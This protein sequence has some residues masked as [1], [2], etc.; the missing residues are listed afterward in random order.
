MFVVVKDLVGLPG[1]PATTKGIR[2]A[3]ERASGDSPA[4]VRKREGSKAFEY[5]IDCL[6]AAVREV[7]LARRAEAVLQK[8]EVQGQLPLEPVVPAARGRAEALRVSVE[9][10][11]MRKCPALLE[12]QLGSLTDKQRKTGDARMTLVA[13]V[14]RL[15]GELSMSRK[16]AVTL[17]SVRSREG[18]LPERVQQAADIANARKGVTRTGVSVRSLQQWV[19]DAMTT[20]TAGE[21]M[22]IMAP[23]KIKAKPAEAYPWLSDFMRFYRDPAR[24]S[25]A[26]AYERFEA[27]WCLVNAGND[28]MLS[29]LPRVDTVR[30]ALSKIP[31]AERE[32]GRRTGSDYKSLLPHVRRDW[33]KLSANSVWIGDGHGMKMEVISPTTGKPFRPEITLVIDGRTRVVVG[34]SLA[35]SESQMAVGDAIRHAVSRFGVPL[36]YYSDNG[37]GEKNK[38]FDADVT[39]IFSRLEIEH[40][41][42]IPGNPQARGIIERLNQEIPKRAAMA[43]GSWVGKSGDRETQRKYVKAVESAVNAIENG[44]NLNER[45]LAVMH[46]VPTWEQLIAE[47]EHQVERHNNRPHSS[48]PVREDGKHW[49]PLA[50]RNHVIKEE[51]TEIEMLTTAELHEMF[52]PEKICTAVRGEIHLNKNVYFSTELARVEGEKVRVCYDIHDPQSVIIRHMDGSW[53][54]DAIWNGNKVSAFPEAREA[55]LKEKR[56]KQRR[57]R[58]EQKLARVD[59]ELRPAIEQKPEIDISLFSAPNSNKEPDQ[60]YLFESDYEHDLKKAGNHR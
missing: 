13:E 43:F 56:T 60:V 24:P 25:V 57:K 4:L 39:G 3:L 31:K 18:T 42:G 38:V 46:K 7:V 52:R 29:M 10:E 15:M 47:I 45:Q 34:W 44:K 37:G 20:R 28:V 9:L 1:L 17:I 16:D 32:R 49:S 51:N 19:S 58:L 48:L 40:P 21:R 2:E 55:Q 54:C 8:P 11:V 5:H 50:Y 35:V 53:I 27:E 59:E 41:T 12:R 6:P 30:Y 14:R 33:E 23:A 22:A 36:M 26:M